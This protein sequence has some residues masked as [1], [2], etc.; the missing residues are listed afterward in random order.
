MA[1]P[2]LEEDTEPLEGESEDEQGELGF[3]MPRKMVDGEQFNGESFYLQIVQMEQ[4][5]DGRTLLWLSD[6]KEYA[7]F[8]LPSK[9]AKFVTNGEVVD[10]S[11]IEIKNYKCFQGNILK[12]D[13]IKKC[14]VILELDVIQKE[15]EVLDTSEDGNGLITH[16]IDQSDGVKDEDAEA[17]GNKNQPFNYNSMSQVANKGSVAINE[18]PPMR[19]AKL[20]P[21]KVNSSHKKQSSNPSN[22]FTHNRSPPRRPG[23]PAAPA[24]PRNNY[25]NSYVAISNLN[26]YNHSWMIKAMVVYVGEP[27]EWTNQSRSGKVWSFRIAD[28]QGTEIEVTAFGDEITKFQPIVQK[29][30]I[31]AISKGKVGVS[32]Y[33]KNCPH[34]Y[35]ITVQRTTTVVHLEGEA[36][37]SKAKDYVEIKNLAQCQMESLVNVVGVVTAVGELEVFTSKKGN[38]CRKR[39]ITLVDSSMSSVTVAIWFQNADVWTPEK[40]GENRVA[41]FWQ[42]RVTEYNGISLSS[43]A[44][45]EIDLVS[46]QVQQ[47][48]QTWWDNTGRSQSSFNSL[49]TEN[50]AGPTAKL[51]SWE[52]AEQQ[53]L[54]AE[55]PEFFTM[56]GT[57]TQII[58]DAERPPWYK[59]EPGKENGATKVVPTDDGRWHSNKNNITYDTY[60]PRWVLR[61]VISDPGT[62]G[63][64]VTIFNNT[65]EKFLGVSAIDAEKILNSHLEGGD[66]SEWEAIFSRHL[67]EEKLF[68]IKAK[69][70][71]Y[72]GET[73]IKY[74]C[75]AISDLDYSAESNE[76]LNHL[77]SINIG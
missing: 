61:I 33:K 49:S 59:A 30:K 75:D 10:N 54:G 50:G 71:E 31:Y 42:V 12:I 72:N 35:S 6:S 27:R 21:D 47:K 58:Y 38:E 69:M 70:D 25:N 19:P 15:C 8:V 63:K 62:K 74:Q 52:T 20:F 17:F 73:Q 45:P 14:A 11:I 7:K 41:A 13:D 65:A 43:N 23:M 57:V 16:K 60:E 18:S 66:D 77:A 37:Q 53:R 34:E 32:K 5:S 28:D 67:W 24:P 64:S 22:P 55:G 48:V 39:A 2:D 56:T 51:Y 4:I 1:D 44:G 46:P 76:M 26:P 36:F 68:K 40:F 29:G 3:G 9:H